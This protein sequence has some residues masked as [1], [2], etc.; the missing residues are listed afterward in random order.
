MTEKDVEKLRQLS[1]SRSEPF[2][3][4]TRARVLLGYHQGQ[5]KSH[6]ARSTGVSR[7]TVDLCIMKAS[8]AG[9]EVALRDLPRAAKPHEITADDKA[10]VISLAC[11]KHTD[12]GYA[13]ERWTRSQLAQHIRKNAEVNG[14]SSLRRAGKVTVQRILKE[15][16]LQPH[17][18]ARKSDQCG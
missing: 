7:P 1:V 4:V 10:W 5:R 9:V 15:H 13:V 3:Q 11:S 6:T 14:H 12:F 8:C 17:K 18:T 16:E 2:Q